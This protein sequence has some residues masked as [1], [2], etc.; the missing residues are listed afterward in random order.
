M[1]ENGHPLLLLL[2]KEE[3]DNI[4]DI[5]KDSKFYLTGTKILYE[6]NLIDKLK[7]IK[8]SY[9]FLDYLANHFSIN[10]EIKDKIKKFL[11]FYDDILENVNSIILELK[12][13]VSYDEDIYDERIVNLLKNKE[14]VTLLYESYLLGKTVKTLDP[15]DVVGHY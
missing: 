2:T 9:L 5:A 3:R 10:I 15:S 14:I 11:D 8:D 13:H 1:K 6:K 4:S 12:Y 7:A